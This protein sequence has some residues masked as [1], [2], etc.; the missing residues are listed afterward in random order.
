MR[1]RATSTVTV[2]TRRANTRSA[3][4]RLSGDGNI[5]VF[6][7]WASN[8]LC[9]GRCDDGDIDNNLLPD[10]YLFDRATDRFRRASGAEGTWW[11]PSLGPVLDGTGQVDV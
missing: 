8:L 5:V 7:S 6:E 1:D 3:A 9:R 11:T 10:I 4:P 2:I